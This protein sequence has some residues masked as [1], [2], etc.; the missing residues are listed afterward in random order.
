MK[1][2][3][4]VFPTVS[5]KTLPPERFSIILLIFCVGQNLSLELLQTLQVWDRWG[6]ESCA[7]TSLPRLYSPEYVFTGCSCA[8]CPQEGWNATV[9][10][11]LQSSKQASHSELLSNFLHWR[12]DWQE[13]RFSNTSSFPLVSRT[14]PRHS[15]LTMNTFDK[16]D[17]FPNKLIAFKI[18]SALKMW[19]CCSHSWDFW[20]STD[21]SSS[22][23]Y[24]WQSC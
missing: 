4:D 14:L 17:L 16:L 8:F 12:F 5:P 23:L 3:T 10:H 7:R 1:D 24:L 2:F 9:F 21:D 11:S 20:T 22:L 18:W 6:W 19:R 15:T 13:S